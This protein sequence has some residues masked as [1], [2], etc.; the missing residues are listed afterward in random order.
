MVLVNMKNS[1]IKNQN[2]YLGCLPKKRTICSLGIL[3][4]ILLFKNVVFAK[5]LE[6]KKT[7]DPK[8]PT[9]Q[10]SLINSKS[11]YFEDYRKQINQIFQ[12]LDR[13]HGIHF[14]SD[15]DN[16]D[17]VR[18]SSTRMSTNL[19]TY[20]KQYILNIDYPGFDKKEL[21]IE[22]SG[23]Y[24]I[25]NGKKNAEDKT[26]EEKSFFNQE[27]R[28]S[29]QHRLLIPKDVDTNYIKPSLKNGVLTIVLPRIE[30]KKRQSKQIPIN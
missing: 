29:F 26:D 6:E 3:G 19:A 14:L 12:E 28:N 18:T 27:Y 2:N 13:F 9:V 1:N 4:T 21:G 10:Q 15:W 30:E 25:I 23:D 20:D 17:N 22:V 11:P 8:T 5:E 16:F 24:L 7:E